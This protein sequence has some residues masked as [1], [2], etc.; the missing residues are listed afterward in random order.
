[1]LRRTGKP[2]LSAPLVLCVANVLLAQQPPTFTATSS[3]VA[4]PCSVVDESGNPVTGLT[5]N[6]FEL[7]VDGVRRRVDSLWNDTDRPLLLGVV[8]DISR[9]QATRTVAKERDIERLLE[10]VIHGADRAFVVSVNDRVLLK[11]DV[12][13]GRFG[14][15]YA[16]LPI[17]GEPLG[18]QC[19]DAVGIDGR[20]HPACGGT[21]LWNAIYESAHLKLASPSVN[22]VLVVLSDGNDTGSTHSFAESLEEMKRTGAVVYAVLYPDEM[23]AA[24]SDELQRLS[25]ETG[26]QS[27]AFQG[28]GLDPVLSKLATTVRTRYILGFIPDPTANDGKVHALRV[29]V[30]RSG[31]VVRARSEYSAP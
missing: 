5:L 11:S 28:S 21:A 22:K 20:L 4:I 19:G 14:L 29:T 25:E 24:S 26:G 10:Q 30:R 15:R 9:S 27:F 1:M 3:I 7:Y 2:R 6:D 16:F 8:N 23:G 17:E 31:V 13:R 12:S 18:A